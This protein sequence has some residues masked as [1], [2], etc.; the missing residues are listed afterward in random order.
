MSA[1]NS[2][3]YIVVKHWH[4]FQHYRERRPIFIKTYVELLGNPNY[5]RL[6]F[7]QRGVLQG[8]WLMYAESHC[9]VPLDTAWLSRHL[10]GRVT[11]AT[12]KALNH[13]GFIEFSASKPTSNGASNTR[14]REETEK[15]KETKAE[16][17]DQD[18]P[19]LKSPSTYA[20]ARDE[21]HGGEEPQVTWEDQHLPR[22][23]PPA[24]PARLADV[25]GDV[26]IPLHGLAE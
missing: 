11:R 13:A 15:E 8:I 26:D 2:E 19:L 24:V 20:V 9:E 17:Q 7:V 14:A 5:S 1:D 3:L 4:R 6:T 22:A 23:N 18:L 16:S 12:L 25:L 21:N 10:N